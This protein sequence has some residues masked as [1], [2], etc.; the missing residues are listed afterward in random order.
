MEISKVNK[1]NLRNLWKFDNRYQV[2]KKIFI[3]NHTNF[4]FFYNLS[5]NIFFFL[6]FI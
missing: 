4:F 6:I 3:I 5:N 1:K 2:K